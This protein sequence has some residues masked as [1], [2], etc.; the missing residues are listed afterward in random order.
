MWKA[1]IVWSLKKNQLL[2]ILEWYN[3]CNHLKHSQ[4]TWR[5]NILSARTIWISYGRPTLLKPSNGR[6]HN[7]VAVYDLAKFVISF[8]SAEIIILVG[9]FV[10]VFA[11]SRENQ[12]QVESASF[13][14]WN[15]CRSQVLLVPRKTRHK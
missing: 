8:T 9:L 1:Y 12:K 15:S 2:C 13:C 6:N 3:A 7:N 14:S 10:T 4:S 5:S 11:Q